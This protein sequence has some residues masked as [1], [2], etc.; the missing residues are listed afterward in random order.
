V[1]IYENHKFPRGQTI[2]G[3]DGKHIIGFDF[4]PQFDQHSFRQLRQT[5]YLTKVCNIY[6]NKYVQAFK[7]QST[8]KTVH[9]NIVSSLTWNV[10]ILSYKTHCA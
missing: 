3:N 10:G 4:A 2:S 1:R 8:N 6:T 7:R 5:G 9:I